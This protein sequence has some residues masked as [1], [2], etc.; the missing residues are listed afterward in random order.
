MH[1]PRYMTYGVMGRGVMGG[2]MEE[3]MMGVLG[4]GLGLYDMM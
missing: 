1:D 4:L 3:G 2:G